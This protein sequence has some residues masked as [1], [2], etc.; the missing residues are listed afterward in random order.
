[1]PHPTCPLRNGPH[2]RRADSGQGLTPGGARDQ[3]RDTG[4]SSTLRRLAVGCLAVIQLSACTRPGCE[5]LPPRRIAAPDQ[6]AEAVIALWNCG[7]TTAYEYRVY[8]VRPGTVVRKDD[9]VLRATHVADLSVTWA[10]S[11]LLHIG[12]GQARILD[13]RNFWQDMQA[14]GSARQIDI[15]ERQAPAPA[16]LPPT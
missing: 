1:M 4:F 6:K 12:D 15:V 9:Q 14:D 8:V 2:E 11:T 5:E 13:F 10:S 7:A 3:R 16:P